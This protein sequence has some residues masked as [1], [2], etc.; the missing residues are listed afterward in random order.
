MAMK[1]VSARPSSRRGKNTGVAGDGIQLKGIERRKKIGSEFADG[2]GFPRADD[3]IR[4]QTNP[5]GEVADGWRENLR[6]VS[7]F[8]GSVRQTL[9]PLAINVA[10]RQQK[11]SA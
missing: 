7:G 5:S 3:K 4:E 2:H 8:A 10:H 1:T 11:N 6:G 9:H